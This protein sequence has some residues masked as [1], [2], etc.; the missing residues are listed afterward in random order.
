M[1]IGLVGDL[2]IRSVGILQGN[3]ELF[4]TDECTEEENMTLV[5][6]DLTTESA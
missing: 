1:L 5:C 6:I 3:F 4:P 2:I